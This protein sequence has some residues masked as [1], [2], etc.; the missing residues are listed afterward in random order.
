MSDNHPHS[1]Q[2]LM[3]ASW[4]DQELRSTHFVGQDPVPY[5]LIGRREGRSTRFWDCLSLTTG[6]LV[7][8]TENTLYEAAAEGRRIT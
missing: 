7:Q 3:L 6:N 4:H 8:V 2:V 1:G 5:L